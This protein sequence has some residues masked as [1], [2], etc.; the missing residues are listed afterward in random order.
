MGFVSSL[1]SAY[2]GSDF[3]GKGIFLAL[4]FLSSFSWTY[5]VQ[6]LFS[7]IKVKKENQNILAFLKNKSSPLSS[8]VPE[9][10]GT[11]FYEI[12]TSLQKQT[13]TLLQKN[14][15]FLKTKK[16][17]FLDSSDFSVLE[18]ILFC[19]LEKEG[20]LLEKNLFFLP[21]ATSLAP[22]LGL[23][24]TVWGI[25]LTFS[26]M[27]GASYGVNSSILPHLSMAL[28]TTV[29]GL[30]VAIPSL[31]FYN[32]L[33]NEIEKIKKEMH[34]FAQNLMIELKLQYRKTETHEEIPVSEGSIC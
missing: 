12:Y 32:Y 19:A 26:E 3:L 13:K 28:A 16:Q 21:T 17:T 25:L 11:P 10:P 24:G 7:F 14:H 9:S 6:R 4:L 8:P 33:K 27:K 15:A 34:L 31:L 30:I 2:Q 1:L 22:F 20:D 18:N 5:F 29:A 23:L